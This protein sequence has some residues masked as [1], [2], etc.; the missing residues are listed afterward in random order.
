MSVNCEITGLENT[1]EGG[2]RWRRRT[3]SSLDGVPRHCRCAPGIPFATELGPEIFIQ[4]MR[5]FPGNG[6]Y[7]GSFSAADSRRFNCDRVFANSK[8]YVSASPCLGISFLWRFPS[9]PR[10][11]HAIARATYLTRSH[12]R[13]L[14]EDNREIVS[15]K[16]FGSADTKIESNLPPAMRDRATVDCR[17]ERT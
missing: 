10:G 1:R 3:N 6:L 14:Y 17:R 13:S 4:L 5:S 11:G 12:R 2:G 16:C 15:S 9:F 7:H 8:G